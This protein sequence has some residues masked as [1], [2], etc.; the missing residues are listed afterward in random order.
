VRRWLDGLYDA[1]LAVAGI[2]LIGMFA[3]M[4][5]E[6]VMRTSGSF[7]S[8]ASELVG[9]FSAAAGFLALPATF[10][11]GE[12]VRV[13]LLTD[14]LS[15]RVRKPVLIGCALLAIAFTAYMLWAVASYLWSSYRFGEMTQGMIYIPAWVP[16]LSF[17]VG[18]AL[19]LVSMIDMLTRLLLQ[20]ADA[21][22]SGTAA[23][24]PGDADTGNA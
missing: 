17:M 6:A 19:L 20:T 9:W 8:G 22:A 12:M 4:V 3:V 11:R 15:P 18:V 23:P 14:R 2:F 24:P 7:L 5:G 16:Q 1:S 21:A 10:I 13:S